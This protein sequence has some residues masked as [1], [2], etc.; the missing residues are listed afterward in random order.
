M[1]P[2]DSVAPAPLLGHPSCW[3]RGGAKGPQLGPCVLCSWPCLLADAFIS[4]G[5][6]LIGA[7]ACLFGEAGCPVAVSTKAGAELQ[8]GC[9]SPGAWGYSWQGAGLGSSCPLQHLRPEACG[10]LGIPF[11]RPSRPVVGGWPALPEGWCPFLQMAQATSHA[12]PLALGRQPSGEA[13]GCRGQVGGPRQ[14]CWLGWGPCNSLCGAQASAL[15]HAHPRGS[16]SEPRHAEDSALV[17]AAGMASSPGEKSS[18][19]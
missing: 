3:A 5:L 16:G 8:G 9:S 4:T 7:D 1:L 15:C 14:S 6:R 12:V 13:W 18:G 2:G 19:R 11:P 10:G 17:M